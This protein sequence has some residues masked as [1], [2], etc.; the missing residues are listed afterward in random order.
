MSVT[1][2]ESQHHIRSRNPPPEASF[3][4]LSGCILCQNEKGRLDLQNAWCWTSVRPCVCRPGALK[5]TT[6]S[7]FLIQCRNNLPSRWMLKNLRSWEKAI[8]FQITLPASVLSKQWHT[9][10]FLCYV[11]SS[12][13]WPLKQ[14]HMMTSVLKLFFY[15][16]FKDPVFD[17]KV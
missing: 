15:S 7:A 1:P 3:L 12:C 17:V 8:K 10:A 4:F 13:I 5:Q 16:R 11:I 14:F 2:S 9:H 6:I